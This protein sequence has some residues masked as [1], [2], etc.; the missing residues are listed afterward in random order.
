MIVGAKTVDVNFIVWLIPASR[1]ADIQL[2]VRCFA[3]WSTISRFLQ[4]RCFL[5]YLRLSERERCATSEC[6]GCYVTALESRPVL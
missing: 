3:C 2:Y 4:R 6:V 1:Y 5:G